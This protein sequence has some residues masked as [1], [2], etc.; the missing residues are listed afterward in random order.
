MQLLQNTYLH[1]LII[2]GIILKAITIVLNYKS[3]NNNN[4]MNS[5]YVSLIIL[6]CVDTTKTLLLKKQIKKLNGQII[7]TK[8]LPY[9]KYNKKLFKILTSTFFELLFT[10]LILVQIFI[11]FCVLDDAVNKFNILLYSLINF[12]KFYNVYEII[13]CCDFMAKLINLFNSD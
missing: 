6:L 11:T 8:N 4:L 10:I 3:L 12:M 9:I 7:N 1:C 2:I 13:I 5:N